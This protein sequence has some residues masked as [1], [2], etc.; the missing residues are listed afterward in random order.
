M[1]LPSSHRILVVDDNAVTRYSV[2]RVLEHHQFVVEEAG[3]GGEGLVRLAAEAFAAVVLDVNLPDMSGFDIVRT[4]R[5]EPRTALLPVVHVSAASIAT[6]DMITGLDAG[7]DAYLI[8]PVDPNVLVATLRTL[9]RARNAEEALRLSEARFREIFEHIGA[10][11]AVVDAQLHTQEAN[12]AFQRLIGSATPCEAI[13]VPG[14]DQCATVQALTAALGRRER[15]SGTLSILRDGAVRETEWRVSPY[16]EPD[17]GLLFVED[18]TEQRLREREQR[19]ELDTATSELAHQIAERQRT[20]I[21]LLQAQKMEALG[22]LTGGIAHDF[23]NLLT[24]IISGLDMIQ[25]AVESNRIERVP[26][27]AEIATGSA[28]RA[29]ALTQRML[30][31]ARKQSLD[32]QPFDVNARVRSLEDMLRRSIGENIA[33]ELQLAEAPLVAIADANQLENVVLNLVINARDALQGHGTIRIQ[34]A[35]HTAYNDPEL[36]DGDYVA[37]N[38]IDDGSGI[39]PAILSQVFEPF[40]TTKPIGEGTGLGLSMTY[41]F[42]RQSGGTARITSTLGSG[43]T[44]ALLLPRG[45]TVGEALPPPPPNAPRGRSQRI[46]LVDDTD[47]VRMMV[48]EV[49][50]DAG[51]HVI[52]AEN[53]DGALAQLRAD[54]QIDM[55]VSDVGLPGMNGRDMADVARDL[56]PGL[57]ILFITGYAENAATRQ[58]FLAEGMALLP[59]PFSL[60]DLLNTVSRMLG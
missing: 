1:V 41:G 59:K 30:A 14:L 47:V 53:A 39:D 22:K 33:L 24:S 46:L 35:P 54:A 20:E 34:S 50:S 18:V 29:A 17:L 28:H 44:V 25:L 7:A 49:L 60:N 36:E 4:L 42:A 11:I 27:L 37:V 55:V 38:V 10:P 9:L 13:N 45:L 51:Y 26:R 2:R 15:W 57:P 12:A 52:E 31:F 40:F 43:T 8:H 48:S 5:A 23:N 3:T 6:G 19:Q 16:R 56:R 58:E 21:Q 32:A